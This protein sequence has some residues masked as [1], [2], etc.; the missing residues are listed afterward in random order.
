MGMIWI[1][2]AGSFGAEEQAFSALDHGHAH[3]VR[4]AIGYLNDW[5]RWAIN[6]DHELQAAGEE[7]AHGFTR[8]ALPDA[9]TR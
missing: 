5:L 6:R 3:A 1:K 7:P 2:M 4:E 9:S 8:Q